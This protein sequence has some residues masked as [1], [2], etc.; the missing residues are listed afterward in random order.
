[1]ALEVAEVADSRAHGPDR[2]YTEISERD[3]RD[4][5]SGSHVLV[6][7][8]HWLDRRDAHGGPPP[9]QAI[10]PVALRRVLRHIFLVEHVPDRDDYR[11]R[12]AG[13]AV[14][15]VMRME[16]T[17]KLVTEVFPPAQAECVL[18]NYDDLR[19]TQVARYVDLALPEGYGAPFR[20]RRLML[21]LQDGLSIG[22]LDATFEIWRS[23]L[24][25][26]RVFG[27]M[28]YARDYKVILG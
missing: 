6:L 22:C 13:T 16:V 2:V 5:V 15:S 24:P 14:C 23:D 8:D 11:F 20:Y 12:L 4:E 21:P 9:R 10:D 26:F 28:V 19:L 17:G 27:D 7:L 3:F 25:F 1:M 18:R